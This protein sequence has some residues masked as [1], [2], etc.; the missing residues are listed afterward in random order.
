MAQLQPPPP[1]FFCPISCELMVDP[2][3]CSDGH[4]YDRSNIERWLLSSNMSPVTGLALPTRHLIP[5]HALRNA[6]EEFLGRQGDAP[7]YT[8]P[9]GEPPR[10]SVRE[11]RS[12]LDAAGVDTT[13]C[14]ERS[15][16]EALH[17]ALPKPPADA[18]Q[19]AQREEWAQRAAEERQRREA[20]ERSRREAEAARAARARGVAPTSADDAMGD[21]QA[22]VAEAQ[23]A[24]QQGVG[25]A[26]RALNETYD[27]LRPAAAAIG[28]G[29]AA[30]A[31]AGAAALAFGAG[32]SA[33]PA[34]R[35]SQRRR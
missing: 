7:A 33:P 1:S 22:G 17:A 9:A 20:T 5:N 32:P 35:D 12:T 16:L 34:R 13:G 15:E 8:A 25:D 29:V 14:T 3:T 6:I 30:A 24:V 4:S 27:A 23:R 11:L 19:R 26:Q 28:L 31:V 10:L 2:V 21:L 18:E